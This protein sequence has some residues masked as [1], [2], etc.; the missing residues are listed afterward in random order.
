MKEQGVQQVPTR[1]RLN[2]VQEVKQ[3]MSAT[4][5]QLGENVEARVE[6]ER[7]IIVIDLT[8]R[9]GR[10]VSG[11]TIRVASTEGNRPIPGTEVIV[12]INAYCK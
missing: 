10:S 1:G 12:G 8:H 3:T 4:I 5:Y 9:G 2:Q 6:E 11:K 7:L